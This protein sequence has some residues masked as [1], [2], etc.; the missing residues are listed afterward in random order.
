LVNFVRDVRPVGLTAHFNPAHAEEFAAYLRK[1]TVAPN[2]HRNA[3]KRPLRDKGVKYILEVCRNLFNYA[4][5]RRHLPP[6]AENPFATIEIERIPVEDAKPFVGFSTQQERMFLEVCDDWQFPVFAT[7]LMTGSRDGHVARGLAMTGVYTHSR[8]ET[9]RRQLEEAIRARPVAEV[10]RNWLR[11]ASVTTWS[12]RESRSG[13]AARDD[14]TPEV[15][16]K[17]VGGVSAG[18]SATGN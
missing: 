16:T 15:T 17:L 12:T 7:L 8:P 6:Y 3:A 2:G 18:G 9:V 5:K 4:A 11:S 1:I 13:G 10:T 14:L